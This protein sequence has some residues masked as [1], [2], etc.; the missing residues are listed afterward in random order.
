LRSILK[1]LEAA[2]SGVTGEPETETTACTGASP[3]LVILTG[4]PAIGS[5][6]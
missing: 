4:L 2:G 5:A 3:V 6:L 1:P